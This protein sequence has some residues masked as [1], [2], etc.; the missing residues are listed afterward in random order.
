MMVTEET[1]QDSEKVTFSHWLYSPLGLWPLIF[2]FHDHFTDGSL[3]GRVISSSQG[4]YLNTGQHIHIPNIHALCGIRTHDPGF[5]ASEDSTCLRPLGYRDRLG[6]SN[7]SYLWA[8]TFATNSSVR[9]VSGN[10]VG[11][12]AGERDSPLHRVQTASGA[13][14]VSYP[15]RTER[16]FP[17]AVGAWIWPLTST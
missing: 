2:Q 8:C 1:W 7:V 16:R 14:T 9:I 11:V 13:H 10:G 12:P 5:R 4:L 3:L 15:I 6:E 17:Q